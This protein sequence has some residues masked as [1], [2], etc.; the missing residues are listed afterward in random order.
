MR[1]LDSPIRR[2]WWERRLCASAW[3]WRLISTR[4]E[5]LIDYRTGTERHQ[6]PEFLEAIVLTL[7]DPR[8]SL[9]LGR[10]AEAQTHSVGI[11]ANTR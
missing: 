7:S 9:F 2:F 10:V 6:S 5:T 4:A 8:V 1:F 11:R 3:A